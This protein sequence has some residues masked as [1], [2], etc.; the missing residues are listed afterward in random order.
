M[1]L[2]GVKLTGFSGYGV[3]L[4]G[5]NNTLT[6]NWIGTANGTTAA[7]NANGIW[8]GGSNNKLGVEAD[9]NSRNVVSGNTGVGVTVVGGADNEASHLLVGY[10]ADGTTRL[11]NAGGVRVSGGKLIFRVGNRVAS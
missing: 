2:K 1:T 5:N 4:T 7:P 11:V 3:R 9:P 10:A 6:C 8:I